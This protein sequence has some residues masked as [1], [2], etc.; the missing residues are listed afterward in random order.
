MK[1]VYALLGL[2]ALAAPPAAPEERVADLLR[3]AG[4]ACIWAFWDGI[5]SVTDVRRVDCRLTRKEGRYGMQFFYDGKAVPGT[6]TPL[7]EA[8]R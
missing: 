5:R 7:G 2:T 4:Q 3:Q 1:T 8:R 6:W